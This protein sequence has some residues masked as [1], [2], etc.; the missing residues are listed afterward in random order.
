LVIIRS[1][2]NSGDSSASKHSLKPRCNE[3][4]ITYA[5]LLRWALFVASF[6]PFASD[7]NRWH[8]CYL[9]SPGSQQPGLHGSEVEALTVHLL[10]QRH[11]TL[12]G[13]IDVQ[14]S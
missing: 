1:R 3:P 8:C 14:I 7:G 12:V 13:L 6:T 4:P 11:R 9:R 2:R 5:A 10:P